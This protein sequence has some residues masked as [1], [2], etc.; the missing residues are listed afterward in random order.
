VATVVGYAGAMSDL[1]EGATVTV[2][3]DTGQVTINEEEH[4]P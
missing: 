1:P 3:G 2:N 4:A